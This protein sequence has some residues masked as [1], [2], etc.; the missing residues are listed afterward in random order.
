MKIRRAWSQV[1]GGEQ[2]SLAAAPDGAPKDKGIRRTKADLAKWASPLAKR[3]RQARL[4]RAHGRI[5]A[6]LGADRNADAISTLACCFAGCRSR[7]SWRGIAAPA[8][9]K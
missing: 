9:S 3:R 2:A 5:L 1:A 8:L 4:L 6:A 7:G